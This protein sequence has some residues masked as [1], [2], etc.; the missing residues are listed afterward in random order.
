MDLVLEGHVARF[1]KNLV[2]EELDLR[3]ILKSYQEEREYRI[4]RPAQAK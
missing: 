4:R 3:E 1:V 2:V